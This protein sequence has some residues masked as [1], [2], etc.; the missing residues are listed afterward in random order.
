MVVIDA[1]MLGAEGS[2]IGRYTSS[3]LQAIDR[4]G[5][6]RAVRVWVSPTA[7]LPASV[8]RSVHLD[9]RVTAGD[10]RRPGEQA[11]ARRRLR[12]LAREGVKVLH[13][14]DVFAPLWGPRGGR[15]GGAG[16]A[17]V[18]TLH[19]VI[20]LVCRGQLARSRKQRFLPLWRAWLKAQTRR[21]AAVVTVSE[22]SANDITRYLGVPR[23]KLHVIHNAVPAPPPR[24]DAGAADASVLRGL[25][26]ERPYLLNVGRRDPYK[27][28]PGLV[29][30]FAELRDAGRSGGLQLVVVGAADPRYPE[31]ERLAATLGVAEAVR[32]LGWVADDALAALYRGAGAV[33]LPSC[34]EGFGLPALEA[35]HAG[36]AGGRGAGGVA[37]GGDRRCG[38][39]FRPPPSGGH[40][41]GDPAGSGRRRP[42]PAV[43]R[44]GPTARRSVFP[45]TFR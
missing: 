24:P 44:A 11:A 26:V 36:G 21:A 27:N 31:A 6:E 1:R 22:H 45:R 2:G 9:L 30:A 5:P 23:E 7:A 3:L 10:P 34:Y 8:E 4:V 17:T 15:G 13:C 12:A 14:P 42:R 20:P 18:V 33:V 39:A 25:G 16:V 29:R 37:A 28:V 43:G 19:D 35:M 32:F 40:G 41:G 38:R